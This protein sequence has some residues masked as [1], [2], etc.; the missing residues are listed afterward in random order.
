MF[1][2]V[3]DLPSDSTALVTRLNVL[4]RP[5]LRELARV[6]R[7]CPTPSLGFVLTGARHDV[8]YPYGYSEYASEA[9]TE[10]AKQLTG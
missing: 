4:R 7:T 1:A 10:T 8:A 6:L 3:D 9:Y 5:V 2:A